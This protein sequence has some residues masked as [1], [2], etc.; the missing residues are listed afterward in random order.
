VLVVI[1]DAV[2]DGVQAETYIGRG[3][4]GG[5]GDVGVGKGIFKFELHEEAVERRKLVQAKADEEQDFVVFELFGRQRGGIGK[6]RG[7]RRIEGSETGEFT[8]L[9][10]SEVADGGEEPGAWVGDGGSLRVKPQEGFLH[11]ILGG[12]EISVAEVAGEMEQTGL[13]GE[14]EG[15][16]I[17][18]LWR[19]CS[20]HVEGGAEENLDCCIPCGF[21]RGCL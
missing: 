1:G 17:R 18:C 12:S 5:A 19:G 13:F 21:G 16:K 7:G 8:A 2:D 9:V 6:C 20:G 15:P 3:K 10:E 4:A 14:K 11:E